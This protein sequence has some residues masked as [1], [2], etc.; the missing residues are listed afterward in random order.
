V[1]VLVI[2][3]ARAV[4]AKDAERAAERFLARPRTRPTDASRTLFSIVIGATLDVN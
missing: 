3:V 2:I 4:L 1:D